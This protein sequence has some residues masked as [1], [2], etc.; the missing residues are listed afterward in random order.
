MLS[1][2]QQVQLLE[3][4]DINFF[5]ASLLINMQ[6]AAILSHFSLDGNGGTSLP[7]DRSLWPSFLSGGLLPPPS[8]VSTKQPPTIMTQPPVTLSSSQESYQTLRVSSSVP[9]Q[10]VLSLS[11]PG[12]TGP[13]MHDYA[14]P[15]ASGITHVRPGVVGVSTGTS[16]AQ[17]PAP[18][19]AL[20]LPVTRDTYRDPARGMSVSSDTWESPVSSAIGRNSYG[21]AGSWS[22]P[23]SS[24]RSRST[25]APKS[26]ED[27]PLYVEVDI[28]GDEPYHERGYG[29][30]TRGR[31]SATRG[32]VKDEDEVTQGRIQEERIEEQWDGE[33]EMEM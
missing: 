31:T 30:I 19:R 10:S 33:M 28:E 13:K 32:G 18:S 6:A 14:I 15:S 4:I 26:E 3:V 29:F 12:S 5:H 8:T 27:D 23:R 7:E 24:E 9:I 25:S 17:T 16:P 2:H 1:K 22:L 21:T 11:R 20:P